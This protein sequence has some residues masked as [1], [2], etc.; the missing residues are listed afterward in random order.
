MKVKL[1]PGPRDEEKISAIRNARNTLTEEQ[2]KEFCSD[3]VNTQDD[4]W[5]DALYYACD[6]GDKVLQ[7]QETYFL[8]ALLNDEKEC[9]AERMGN[10]EW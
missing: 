2:W 7:E 3:C 10:Y 4:T 6:D 1:I 9:Y 5:F 8:D